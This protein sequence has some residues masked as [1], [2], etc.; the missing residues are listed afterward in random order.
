MRR[1]RPATRDHSTTRVIAHGFELPD[2]TD[3]FEVADVKAV[4]GVHAADLRIDG[5][6]FERIH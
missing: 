1:Q 6:E 4:A 5:L 2:A 3:H